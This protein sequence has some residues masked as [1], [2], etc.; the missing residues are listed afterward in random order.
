MA[1]RRHNQG[2]RH[3]WAGPAR[4]N[5]FGSSVPNGALIDDDGAYLLD[6]DGAY[7]LEDT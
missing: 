5:S 2:A 7:L 4:H 3:A 1:R 6:D